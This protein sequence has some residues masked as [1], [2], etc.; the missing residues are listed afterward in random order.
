MGTFQ[1]LMALVVLIFVL[2]VIVQA[3]KSLSDSSGIT[4][5]K[6]TLWLGVFVLVTLPEVQGQTANPTP[7]AAD[8]KAAD[9][10]AEA[11]Q[12]TKSK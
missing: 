7:P 1:T 6:T 11:K 2:R 10:K 3:F 5:A 4:I 8:K 9:K 12:S